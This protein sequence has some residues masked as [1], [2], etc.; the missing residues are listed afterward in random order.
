MKTHVKLKHQDASMRTCYICDETLFANAAELYKHHKANHP[1]E[2]CQ[3][4]PDGVHIH[5]CDIC[6][7][8][9]A[10]KAAL[11]IHWKLTHKIKRSHSDVTIAAQGQQTCQYCQN[12]QDSPTDL[13][14][15]IIDNHPK[16]I[17]APSE[18]KKYLV[19]KCRKCDLLFRSHKLYFAHRYS[20]CKYRPDSKEAHGRFGP[21]KSKR[22]T[23]DQKKRLMEEFK[24]P[25]FCHEKAMAEY[26]VSYATIYRWTRDRDPDRKRNKKK[27]NNDC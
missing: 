24:M 27:I 19:F 25:G 5:Q 1:G 14:D 17:T 6:Q 16:V 23:P 21:I 11:Y 15:H 8:I 2:K 7:D 13:I 3:V 18:L 12:V 20:K 9:L 22:L 10:S 4:E 26:G